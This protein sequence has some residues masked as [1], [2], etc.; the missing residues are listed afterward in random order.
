MEREKLQRQL[1][2][3]EE[4]ISLGVKRYREQVANTPVSEFGPGLALMYRTIEPLAAAI[5]EFV[6]VPKRGGARMHQ[7]REFLSQFDPYDVAYITAKDLLNHIANARAVQIAARSI[8]DNLVT[9]LEYL[10]MVEQCPN[11]LAVV[12]ER[13]N[14][15]NSSKEHRKTALMHLKRHSL[16]IEDTDWS[17]VDKVHIGVKLIDLFIEHTGLIERVQ[18]ETSQ[19]ILQGTYETISWIAKQNARCELLTPVFLPMIV[20]PVPWEGLYGGGYLGNYDTMRTKLVKTRNKDALASLEKHDM[21]LVYKAV[22]TLQEV[23]WRI[24]TKVLEVLKEVHRLD[25]GLAGL[26]RSEELPL[27]PKPWSTDEEFEALKESNPE[28]VKD[29][30]ARARE[31]Y[32]RRIQEKSK[33]LQLVH[34]IWIAEKFQEEGEIYFIWTLD[35]RGRMYPL[36]PFLNPQGDD[37]AKALLQFAEGKPL[38]DD[39]GVYWLAVHLA[40]TFGHDKIPF[41]DRVK[42]TKEHSDLIMDSAMNPLTGQRFWTEADEPWQFLAACFEW[43]GYMEQGYNHI[44]HI[45]IHMDGSCN[46]LQNFSAMLLDEVGGRATNLVPMNEPQDVYREVME[47][48]IRKVDHD[49]QNAEKE[50]V[51]QYARLWQGK[52]DR[53]LVKRPVMTLPYGVKL[54]GIKDQIIDELRKRDINYLD[55]EDPYKPAI[56]LAN[57]LWESIGEVV[58]ASRQA[59]DWLQEVAGVVSKV[60]NEAI[61]WT[62]PA[63][64]LVYQRY[65]KVQAR[66]IRTFWGTTRVRVQLAVNEE[67][68]VLDKVK[69]RNGISPNF[70]HSM[71]A[72][73]LMLTIN[74]LEEVGITSFSAV[75]DSYGTHPCD[76]DKLHKILRQTFVSQYSEDVLLQFKNEIERQLPEGVADEIPPL[77]PK[78]SLFL[79]A[80]QDSPYFF[81]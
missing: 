55:C 48:V 18:T 8:F 68:T 23:P 19:W 11:Y 50:E 5:T 6:N 60:S 79:G 2:L 14:K 44:S 46:G 38:G 54:Y 7:A 45:P 64:F 70:V 66:T 15:T 9:H 32:E 35:W 25:N 43:Q 80:V 30:K 17:D 4:S 58:I 59:M 34:K 74:R 61:K 52:I 41:D 57:V 24:N 16:G 73:H 72:S 75:H 71:D 47:V 76:V 36:Q 12:E 51:R 65:N 77:P 20:K 39:R 53:N 49:A 21:P 28:V 67:S 56:Y 42:W 63:G 81:A 69:Q 62:T 22:N 3:E 40:N 10:K 13:L 78:G 29:W 26:P 31:V 33:L 1:Q 37:V 27:P